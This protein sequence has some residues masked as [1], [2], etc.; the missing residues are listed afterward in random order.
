MT[1]V[2]R[3]S[4][5]INDYN[6]LLYSHY[7]KATEQPDHMIDMVI[8]LSVNFFPCKIKYQVENLWDQR[9]YKGRSVKSWI[10]IIT[11]KYISKKT[12]F[13]NLKNLRVGRPSLVPFL[14][15]Q[16]FSTWYL[17]LHRQKITYKIITI[18]IIWSGRSMALIW[19]SYLF[20]NFNQWVNFR[21]MISWF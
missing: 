1:I 20:T 9:K 18:S 19:I 6:S 7:P 17:I 11:K 21:Y 8:F 14:W 15:S 10:F 16:E 3:K 12:F 5:V 2:N 13:L 4:I